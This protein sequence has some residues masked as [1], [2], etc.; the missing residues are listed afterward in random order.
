VLLGAAIQI[1]PTLYGVQALV[2]F[3]HQDAKLTNSSHG[4][5]WDHLCRGKKIDPGGAMTEADS[6]RS[7]RNIVAY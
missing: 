6:S 3:Y 7:C 4:K 2:F 1:L 5:L